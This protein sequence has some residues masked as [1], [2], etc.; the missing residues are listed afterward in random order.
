MLWL[1]DAAT[2]D[3][4]V[5]LDPAKSPDNIDVTS[6]QW[7]PQGDRLLLDGRRGALA[8]RRQ[9]GRAS[10]RCV[11]DGSAK[12]GHDVHARRR[13]VSRTCRTTTCTS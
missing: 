12:T 2:G 7:S 4:K 11:E 9:N 13:S 3:K 10:S 6:A 8:A 1:Y 5:L